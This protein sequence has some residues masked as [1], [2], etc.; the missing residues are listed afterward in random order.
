MNDTKIVIDAGHGGNDPGAVG[1]GYQE[2][3]I[4]SMISNYMFN[5]FNELGIPVKYIR[6]TDETL[7]PKERTRQILAAYGNDPNVLVISNH[8]NAGGGESQC[9]TKYV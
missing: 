7:S 8:I 3:N 6:S 5:R 2:K 4:N 1:N 9:V